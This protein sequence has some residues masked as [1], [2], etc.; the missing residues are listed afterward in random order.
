MKSKKNL[1]YSAKHPSNM[2]MMQEGKNLEKFK[3]EHVGGFASTHPGAAIRYGTEQPGFPRV[4]KTHLE[5]IEFQEA[6]ERNLIENPYGTAS[7][8]LLSPEQQ[9]ELKTDLLR[10]G[11][12]AIKKYFTRDRGYRK[13]GLVSP[14]TLYE[15]GIASMFRRG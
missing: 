1:Q 14:Q 3:P 5:P 12:A 6:V 9:G 15:N 2:F 7:D 13:G 11:I 10:T 4:T 8:V